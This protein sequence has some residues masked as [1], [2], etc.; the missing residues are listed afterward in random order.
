MTRRLA[1]LVLVSGVLAT[2]C[3]S[4]TLL[5]AE[6]R[7]KLQ[8]DLTTGPAAVRHLQYSSYVT[9][10]FGDASKRLLTPYPPEEVRLLNDTQGNPINPG[11]VQAMAPAGTKVRV[12]KVEFPTAWVMAERVLY[13][14]RTQPWVYLEV[15]G[16][17]AGPPVILVLPPQLKTKEDV[18]AEL[19]R[20]LAEHELGPRMGKFQQRFQEAIRQ[21][22][23]LEYMPEGAVEMS[24]GPPERIRR[25]LD[26][27]QVHQE[28]V[29]PG[30]KR[31]VFITDGLVTRVDEGTPAAANP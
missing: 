31:R 13:S 10:F 17:P 1:L 15:E 23:V 7:S 11:A 4:Q 2:G 16:V 25:T 19:D 27:Q 6:D 5:S 30:E 26:G 28:W 18:K 22:K 8:Q 20:H 12:L 3:A 21:K 24:W 14:P 29:Y 9:P